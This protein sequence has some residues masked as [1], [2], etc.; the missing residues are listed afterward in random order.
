VRLPY[1]EKK[2]YKNTFLTAKECERHLKANS[3]HYT[4]KSV[5]YGSCTWRNSNI[6]IIHELL[7][8]IAE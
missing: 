5:S 7:K 4:E 2:V 3:H 8:S 1:K 6:E